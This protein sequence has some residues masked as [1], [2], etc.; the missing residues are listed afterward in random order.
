MIVY[1]FVMQGFYNTHCCVIFFNVT[2]FFCLTFCSEHDAIAKE[3]RV[4]LDLPSVRDEDEASTSVLTQNGE[5]K[6]KRRR[7]K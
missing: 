2:I 1:T 5:G 7:N 4:F 6:V 3:I